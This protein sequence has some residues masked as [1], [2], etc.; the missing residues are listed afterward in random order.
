MQCKK[1]LILWLVVAATALIGYA[2][3]MTYSLNNVPGEFGGTMLTTTCGGSVPI[4]DGEA[5]VYIYQDLDY[6][7]QSDNDPLV[8]VCA[9]P[10]NECDGGPIGTF[11]FNSFP[12]NGQETLDQAGYFVGLRY[13]ISYANMPQQPY[14]F[15]VRVKYPN[16]NDPQVTWVSD[17][18]TATLGGVGDWYFT[19]WTCVPV[20][21]AC[22]PAPDLVITPSFINHSTCFELCGIHVTQITIGPYPRICGGMLAWVDPMGCG[23]CYPPPSVSFNP[24]GYTWTMDAPGQ[25]YYHNTISIYADDEEVIPWVRGCVTLTYDMCL[26]VEMGT[27]SF[28]PLNNKVRVQWNTLSESNLDRFDIVRDGSRIG[29]RNATNSATGSEYEF[30]DESVENG[31]TYHYELVVVNLDNSTETVAQESVTPQMGSG[32]VSEFALYQNYPNPFNP[33][34]SISF[35]LPDAENVSL[36]V[37]NL[38]GQPVAELANGTLPS[39]HH[40]ISFDAKALPSG[41][42]VYQLT[43]GSFHAQKKMLLMK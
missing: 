19:Q 10:D 22:V 23:N 34:T 2:Q 12:I 42:Y 40:A 29:S 21:V 36:K 5:I 18:K 3:P 30:T 8:T 26:P 9:N 13:L 28:T 27:V 4:P 20:P 16:T 43:A 41:V 7:G 6:N 14:R 37:F 39:G 31:R 11:N 25:Y 17:I 38:M 33:T 35:D 1:L 15:Y 24:L 32:L